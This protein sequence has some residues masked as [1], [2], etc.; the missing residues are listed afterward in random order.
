VG[1]AEPLVTRWTEAV[2]PPPGPSTATLAAP[3]P[4]RYVFYDLNPEPGDA[5]VAGGAVDQYY[6]ARHQAAYVY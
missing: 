4:Q 1:T 6:E 3:Y 2:G 5:Y